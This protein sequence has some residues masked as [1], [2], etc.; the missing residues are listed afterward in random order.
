MERAIDL[1]SA[2]S[3]S[4]PELSLTEL[5]SRLDLSPTTTY[6]LLVTLAQGS[7]I[8][9]NPQSG[10]YRL[11]VACLKLGGVFLARVELRERVRPILEEL[12]N[13]CKETVHL[14]ILD[15]DLT[16][17]VYLDKLEGLLP[18]V[19]MGSRLG[20]RAPA[21]CTGLGKCLLAY[22]NEGIVH[23]FY[24][25]QGLRRYTPNTITRLDRFVKELARTKERGYAID[26]AEHELDVKC[27]AAAIW[28]HQGEVEGAISVAGPASRIDGLIA[29]QG[30]VDKVKEM[31][32]LASEQMGSPDH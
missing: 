19:A 15:P 13:W 6:R 12:R 30:L 21:H 25:T 3:A 7:Y 28:N 1:L 16:E 4:L 23:D 10:R 26:N 9:K 29:G 22:E 18:V 27:V 14:A 32:H 2:F 24:A 20:G 31:A 8:E 17:V 11:G 5:S